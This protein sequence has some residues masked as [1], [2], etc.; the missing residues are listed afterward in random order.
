MSASLRAVLPTTVIRCE[1]MIPRGFGEVNVER[2]STDIRVA[3]VIDCSSCAPLY[4]VA[5][6]L[7]S[8]ACIITRCVLYSLSSFLCCVLKDKMPLAENTSCLSGRKL[9]VRSFFMFKPGIAFMKLST[10]LTRMNKT[11]NCKGLC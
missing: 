8:G 11:E 7:S 4:I 2:L 9:S 1:C 10:T 3:L 6:P 5:L